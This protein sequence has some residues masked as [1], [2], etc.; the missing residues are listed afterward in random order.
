MEEVAEYTT[1]QPEE[2]PKRN[3][4]MM[5]DCHFC[6]KQ[7]P[8]IKHRWKKNERTGQLYTVHT[9]YCMDCDYTV[10]TRVPYTLALTVVDAECFGPREL[11]E[12]DAQVFARL[13]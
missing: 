5:L 8:Y 1:T 6:H 3:R 12:R 2:K 10:E 13:K 4:W 7:M 9:A 11:L